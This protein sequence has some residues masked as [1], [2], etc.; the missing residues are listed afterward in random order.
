MPERYS[1]WA[2]SL[3]SLSLKVE[4]WKIALQRGQLSPST[5]G[6]GGGGG[7]GR[8]SAAPCACHPRPRD[9]AEP[10]RAAPSRAGG[11]GGT[12][13]GWARRG[14]ARRAPRLVPFAK[15]PAV[16]WPLAAVWLLRD[17]HKWVLGFVQMR[18]GRVAPPR[19]LPPVSLVDD[20]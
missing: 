7:G 14:R 6:A 5:L 19:F 17:R 1:K 4:E 20:F 11:A 9:A 18:V 10:A 15:A 3:L 16:C 2:L 8:E 12:G 13:R